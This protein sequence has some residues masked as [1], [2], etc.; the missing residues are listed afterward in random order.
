MFS[1]QPNANAA[2][3]TSRYVRAMPAKASGEFTDTTSVHLTHAMGWQDF[4]GKTPCYDVVARRDDVVQM[5][6]MT[7]DLERGYYVCDPR[8]HYKGSVMTMLAKVMGDESAYADQ[9]MD[10]FTVVD[11]S[12]LMDRFVASTEQ[13]DALQ[14]E[15]VV[16]TFL[17]T[18]LHMIRQWV[19]RTAVGGPWAADTDRWSLRR[20][21]LGAAVHFTDA[22]DAGGAART[23]VGA[24][25]LLLRDDGLI[26][27]GVLAA[28]LAILYEKNQATVAM[29]PREVVCT[30]PDVWTL[31]SSSMRLAQFDLAEFGSPCPTRGIPVAFLDDVVGAVD[32]ADMAPTRW[33]LSGKS[34]PEYAARIK[35]S[36]GLVDGDVLYVHV[37]QQ[38]AVDDG[39]TSATDGV[40]LVDETFGA[41]SMRPVVAFPVSKAAALIYVA[42]FAPLYADAF[43]K[44]VASDS[45]VNAQVIEFIRAMTEYESGD[46]AVARDLLVKIEAEIGNEEAL[47]RVMTDPRFA[48]IRRSIEEYSSELRTL[49]PCISQALQRLQ[50]LVASNDLSTANYPKTEELETMNAMVENLRC[51]QRSRALLATIARPALDVIGIAKDAS[52]NGLVGEKA[53]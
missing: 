41:A 24:M 28:P 9:L 29:P 25:D 3:A 49:V 18:D 12:A 36:L 20:K 6:A 17:G 7:K 50:A 22:G 26:Q 48:V 47:R 8:P 15:L 39:A 14:G 13:K 44:P 38:H 23:V 53:S 37:S 1:V 27:S 10:V 45:K 34:G 35:A 43:A 31:R 30:S 52:P 46:R 21:S 16:F 40:Y 2:N 19:T 51:I 4:M 5:D 42:G 11:G 33:I 32:G